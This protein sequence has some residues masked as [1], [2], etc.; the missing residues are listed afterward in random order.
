MAK[1]SHKLVNVKDGDTVL[2]AATPIPGHELVFSKTI[3][4]LS[5]AGANVILDKN[6]YM[7]RDMG[8]RKN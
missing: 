5:R 6:K 7:F 3:D 4:L 2:I 1:Q 8:I